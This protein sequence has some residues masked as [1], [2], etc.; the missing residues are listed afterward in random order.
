M[1]IGGL[2]SVGGKLGVDEKSLDGLYFK[3]FL[4]WWNNIFGRFIKVFVKEY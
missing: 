1:V 4:N 2:N 3:V